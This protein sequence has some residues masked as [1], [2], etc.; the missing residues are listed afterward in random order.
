MD[1]V[2][3][4]HVTAK[5]VSRDV[6]I[7]FYA[8]NNLV[9]SAPK[10]RVDLV[11]GEETEITLKASD[12]VNA[13][14]TFD[15]M[16]IAFSNDGTFMPSAWGSA[17][18]SEIKLVLTPKGEVDE[19]ANV[20]LSGEMFSVDTG[21]TGGQF[22]ESGLTRFDGKVVMARDIVKNYNYSAVE[23]TPTEISNVCNVTFKVFPEYTTAI[24]DEDGVIYD[25]LYLY[26]Y[27]P[28]DTTLEFCSAKIKLEVGEWNTV[29]VAGSVF[30]DE[31]GKISKL[32]LGLFER[33]NYSIADGALREEGQISFGYPSNSGK[34]YIESIV[35]EQS[36]Y[37]V[38]FD[39]ATLDSMEREIGGKTYKGLADGSR[40]SMLAIQ[41]GRADIGEDSTVYVDDDK[42]FYYYVEHNIAEGKHWGLNTR[43]HDK[44]GYTTD[45]PAANEDDGLGAS[46]TVYRK[47]F[48]NTWTHP[49]TLLLFRKQ[50]YAKET[51]YLVFRMYLDEF[52]E[53]ATLGFQ[54]TSATSAYPWAYQITDL[55]GKVGRWVD[56]S[57]PAKYFKDKD[58]F[59]SEIVIDYMR[60][61]AECT[62]EE[63]LSFY[64]DAVWYNDVDRV[65]EE[66]VTAVDFSE[67]A[68]VSQSG[69]TYEMSANTTETQMAYYRK[70]FKQNGFVANVTLTGS[71]NFEFF[72]TLKAMGKGDTAGGYFVWFGK[73]KLSVGTKIADDT[74][75]R[76]EESYPEGFAIEDGTPFKVEILTTQYFVDLIPSGYYLSVK[77]NDELVL[78]TPIDLFDSGT[79][80]SGSGLY[81]YPVGSGEGSI[82]V[83]PVDFKSG[84][85][86]V[87][88][89]IYMSVKELKVGEEAKLRNTVSGSFDGEKV[90]GYTVIE[91]AEFAEIDGNYLVAKK[92]GKVKV[93]FTVTNQFGTFSSE[94]FEVEILAG[95]NQ[96][97]AK[98]EEKGG[99]FGNVNGELGLLS[100]ALFAGVATII[101]RRKERV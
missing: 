36:G 75:W 14:G 99:C 67:F 20:F 97:P 65:K 51:G 90:S 94:V 95:E 84:A 13:D 26:V 31:D 41:G 92:A 80:G 33:C 3:E 24:P 74:K 93:R 4:I 1:N 85:N 42:G 73:E 87:E 5:A 44:D 100:I 16:A 34:L 77:I 38:S 83:T 6:T 23:F 56:I 39:M 59:V 50:I 30:A 35:L 58:G 47:S 66:N 69:M 32:T 70:D 52:S 19:D 57:V 91:G 45:Y 71:E 68:P 37:D 78:E 101:R 55:A 48:A 53:T 63:S 49:T 8:Q 40:G 62:S 60:G 98:K 27:A 82:T 88:G 72:F 15:N 2:S 96:E 11:A 12:Y 25:G 43:T 81:I 86:V 28:T 29:T 89:K 64:I 22:I 76:L 46:G 79:L 17:I 9:L 10:Q 7:M 61:D 21:V 54:T 18:I